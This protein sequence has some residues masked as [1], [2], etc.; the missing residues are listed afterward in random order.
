MSQTPFPLYF[1]FVVRI[2]LLI[3]VEIYEWKD[4]KWK[5]TK[6]FSFVWETFAARRLQRES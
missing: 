3:F 2:I 4:K 6:Y 1:T 5:N